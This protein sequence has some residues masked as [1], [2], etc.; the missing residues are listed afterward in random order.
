MGMYK[1]IDEKLEEV[2]LVT[3]MVVMVI[4]IF[5]QVCSRYFFNYSLSWT[6]EVARYI[7]IWQVWLGASFAVKKQRHI[8]VEIFVKKLPGTFKRVVDI[9]ALLLWFFLAMVLA[10]E[11]TQVVNHIFERGQLSPA[12]RMPMWLAYLAVPVGGILMSIRLI[13]QLVSLFR[14]KQAIPSEKGGEPQ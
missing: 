9:T 10:Y 3:T 6:E 2:L 13:Q 11:G 8:R 7:H 5:Y 14:N 4:L 1:W 12:I